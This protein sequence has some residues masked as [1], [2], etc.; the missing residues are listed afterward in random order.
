MVID[1]AN[2]CGVLALGMW[3]MLALLASLTSAIPAFLLL[4]CCFIVSFAIFLVWRC[5]NKQ[6]FLALPKLSG[7]QWFVGIVGLFGFHFCYF[8]ALKHASA[9]EVSLIVY[10]W[11]LLLSV[12]VAN[13]AH[14]FNA[15]IG[16]GLGFIGISFIILSPSE[17][18]FSLDALWGYLLAAAS[19]I[20]WAFYSLFL[21]KNKGQVDD[22]GWLSLAV[23]LLSFIAHLVFES[24]IN[25]PE[26]NQLFGILLLGI[27]PVGGAFYLW[28][29]GLKR[30]NKQL[31][32]S[33]SFFT[34]LVSSI[35]LAFAGLNLW[36]E[37]I[38]VS[39]SL[40][41]LGAFVA[42]SRRSL[43][44]LLPIKSVAR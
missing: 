11:P 6:P 21:S 4:G 39:L 1:M 35:I 42:N 43:T 30:G 20:I 33:L 34:P 10:L 8:F 40:I 37:H 27:G 15:V 9:I 23:A 31:L 24:R 14:K 32:A 44:A 17:Q 25:M 19:A 38:V 18:A 26:I 29:Y 7:K 2:F 36:S 5:V 3:S 28:D 12:L 13:K 22:I 41:L 16:G